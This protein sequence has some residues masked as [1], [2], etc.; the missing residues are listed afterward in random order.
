MVAVSAV[1]AVALVSG[2]AQP[3]KKQAFNREAAGHI[4]TVTLAR[5]VNQV[6][7]EAAVLGHPGMS[8]GL[9]GGLVA[10][11]DMAAKSKRLTTA[12]DAKEMR[13]QDRFAERLRE[14]LGQTGYQIEVTEL[15]KDLGEDK[16]YETLKPKAADAIL[17]VQL[18]AAYWAAGPSTDY[19]PRVWAKVRKLDGKS[20]QVLYE[21]TI[22][23]GYAAPQQQTVHLASRP[24]YRFA[25][26][27]AIEADPVKARAGL[28]EGLQAVAE[29]IAQDLKK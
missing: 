28:Y 12:L 21:D 8:F 18:T 2:C 4:K 3:L 22:T 11:A 20:G 26:M 27:N 5:P 10:A 6:E 16:V 9:I 7:Y 29:Q 23:Y 14:A 25:D 13:A 1:V 17:A 24:E 19:F 15:P